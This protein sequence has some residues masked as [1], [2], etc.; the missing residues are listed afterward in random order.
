MHFT[1]QNSLHTVLQSCSDRCPSI[2]LCLGVQLARENDRQLSPHCNNGLLDLPGTCEFS[3]HSQTTATPP[4][5]I[6]HLNNLYLMLSL[7]GKQEIHSQFW[8]ENLMATK[9]LGNQDTVR[10]IL[11]KWECELI[12]FR[13]GSNSR[14]LL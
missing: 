4:S 8:L 14:N 13:I 7:Q 12:C 1:Q 9:D 6:V 11:L 5:I 3:H 2:R 10:S